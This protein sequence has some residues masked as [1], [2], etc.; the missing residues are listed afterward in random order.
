MTLHGISGRVLFTEKP[1][2]FTEAK[3]DTLGVG[4]VVVKRSS[5]Q[6]PNPYW[7]RELDASTIHGISIPSHVC[8]QIYKR[9]YTLIERVQVLPRRNAGGWKG[10][11]QD[12]STSVNTIISRMKADP[13]GERYCRATEGGDLCSIPTPRLPGPWSPLMEMSTHTHTYTH[14]RFRTVPAHVSGSDCT[15]LGV[16]PNNLLLT[17]LDTLVRQKQIPYWMCQNTQI[18]PSLD[19]CFQRQSL[20]R[21]FNCFGRNRCNQHIFSVC[22]QVSKMCEKAPQNILNCKEGTCILKI[23]SR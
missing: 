23:V 10:W 5:L 4:K 1:A 17:L 9:V 6:N 18:F 11:S 12:A 8:V 2:H 15:R 13:W 21:C 7:F 14:T 20:Q 3:T 16:I 22:F 19:V